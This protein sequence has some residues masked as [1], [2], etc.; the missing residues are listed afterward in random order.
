MMPI[1]LLLTKLYIP[2]VRQKLV[3]RP[4]LLDRLNA[5]LGGRLILLSAPAGSGKTTLLSE[6]IG[7]LRV[8]RPTLN[9]AW[10][11][12]DERDNDPHRFGAYLVATLGTWESDGGEI[13]RPEFGSSASLSEEALTALINRIVVEG[14][15]DYLLV[16]DDY[17][18][19]Q[20]RPIHDALVFLL[21]HMPPRMHLVIATRMDPPLPLPELRAR[22]QLV[23]LRADRLRFTTDEA[24]AFFNTVMELDLSPDDVAALDARTEGWV[25]GLQ[26]AA[27]SMHNCKDVSGFIEAFAG[28]HRYVVDYLADQVLL[29]QS[30][31]IQSFLLE[32][33]ILD[34]LTGPLCDAVT[35]Q[36]HGQVMLEQL[37]AANL[38]IVPLDDERRWYRYHCLLA[39][40]LRNRLTREQPGR[41]GVLHLRAAEW[42]EHSGMIEEAVRHAFAAGDYDLAT[43]LIEQALCV[44]YTRNE[45]RTIIG[46]LEAL[47]QE[48]IR[49]QPRLCASYA[50]ALVASGY[51]GSAGPLLQVTD[52]HLEESL[53]LPER[54]V[55]LSTSCPYQARCA[56]ECYA[57]AQGLSAYTDVLRAQIACYQNPSIAVTFGRRALDRIP[58][59]S[60]RLRGFALVARGTAHLLAG[61]ADAADRDLSEAMDIH[62]AGGHTAALINAAHYL[63]LLRNVQGR[64]GE[65]RAI[66]EQALRIVEERQEPVFTGIEHVGMGD[67]LREWND[68]EAA[69][70]YIERGLRLAESG[71]DCAFL[72]DGYVARARLEQSLGKWDCALVSVRKAEQVVRRHRPAWDTALV[73]AWQAR[74]W[75]ARGDLPAAER[76]ARASG[77]TAG[78]ELSF[79]N[80]FGHMT[81]AR[82]WLAQGRRDQ[83]ARLLERLR[84]AAESAGRMGRVLEILVLQALT[85]QADNDAVGALAALERALLLGEPE[86]YVRTFV[87]EGAPLADL[88]LCGTEHNVWTG[89]N[90]VPYVNRLLFHLGL[91]PPPQPEIQGPE[92]IEP[93]SERELQVLRLVAEGASNQAVAQTLC[94]AVSTVKAHLRNINGKLAVNS[95]TQAVARARDLRLL[96]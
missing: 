5:G 84:A 6:W 17:H 88:L 58:A 45:I 35:G 22:G 44:L 79:L 12:L 74:L 94:V 14:S 92:I 25:T 78:G 30:P 48:L 64:L 8:Q 95:R 70:H 66:Y 9:V 24:A 42:Y 83:A 49:S 34:R 41:A 37:E 47:P 63:A 71:G 68:L 28:T 76:W 36:A 1:P 72:R 73:E 59:G 50:A 65:A 57:T 27:L 87:D 11:S 26:L 91:Q 93:L 39:E 90:L 3:P 38:F 19:I 32:T 15:H 86:G 61:S 20:A 10:L 2:P 21:D 55:P 16:L 18:V 51:L 46:W 89:P 4:H 60:M 7:L 40:L 31:S 43:R 62:Q 80:E 75:L 29:R 33:S 13:A 77:L 56:G 85:L 53:S 81:L 52:S 23:E 67:L 69:S 96:P 82:V 54:A